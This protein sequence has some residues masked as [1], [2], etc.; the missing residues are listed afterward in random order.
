MAK[1]SLSRWNDIVEESNKGAKIWV[2][3]DVH[4]STYAVAILSSNGVQHRFTTPSDNEGLI[5]QFTERGVQITKLAYEAGP[6]GFGL[7]RACV[8]SGIE[9]MI[10]SACRIPRAPTKTPKTDRIDSG[11][12]SEYLAK[13]LLKPI[14]VP[15]KDQEAQRSKSRRRSQVSLAIGKLKER[16]KSFL[17]VNGL[18]EPSGLKH[19]SRG[20]QEGLKALELHPDLRITLDSYVRELEFL[21]GEKSLIEK[22]I[23][24]NEL[25]RKDVLQSVP[26]VGVVTSNIF[27]TEIFDPSR[28]KTAGQMTQYIGLA[29][30]T[31]QS[32]VSKVYSRLIPC[33][34]G[35][36]R[37]VLV[38]AAWRLMSR[39]NW[40]KEFYQR[41]LSNSGK[42]QKAI[43]ALARKLA[44][45]LW[46]LWLENRSYEADYN[47]DKPSISAV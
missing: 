20:G 34:Q 28:F 29:P 5:K 36:L 27:R 14:T 39:E 47:R 35:K 11:K 4:K 42:S 18:P 21:E 31:H 45:I 24:E 30:V 41:V 38:E 26:G 44:V 1:K 7:Y 10:V 22:D 25:S 23:K 13:G 37:S 6:T 17:L 3:V 46:R 16:I 32:G 12:L 40:A 33:G 8:S 43:V 2:G 15:S 9:A 19:W